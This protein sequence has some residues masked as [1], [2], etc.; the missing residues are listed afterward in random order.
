MEYLILVQS[1]SFIL[2]NDILVNK[3][4]KKRREGGF[5][6]YIDNL[7]MLLI[8]CNIQVFLIFTYMFHFLILT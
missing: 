1:Q 2:V 6:F 5:K 7:Y 4:A 8:I 3:Q